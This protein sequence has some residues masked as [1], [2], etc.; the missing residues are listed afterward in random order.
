MASF[1]HGVAASSALDT[2]GERIIIEGMDISSLE[3][4]GVFNYEHKNDQPSQVVGK[5]LKAKKIFSEKDCDNADESYFWEKTQ[6]PFVYVMGELFDD[7][8]E[9]AKE[10]AG[11]FKYDKDNDHK[12]NVCNFS[13][14]GAKLPGS[15]EGMSILRSIARKV[16][17]TVHP[18]NHQAIAEL[19]VVKPEKEPDTLDSIFKTEPIEIELFKSESRITL[20]QVLAKKENPE[21]HAKALGIASMKKDDQK[22]SMAQKSDLKSIM[23]N[24]I[25]HKLSLKEFNP[26]GKKIGTTKGGHEI[27]S[28]KRVHEYSHFHPDDHLEAASLHYGAAQ[29]NPKDAQHHM[30]KVRLHMQAHKTASRREEKLNPHKNEKITKALD[31]GSAMAAPSALSGGAALGMQSMGSMF[32]FGMKRKKKEN[33]WLARAEEEYQTW[34][35]KEEFFNFMQKR[36]PNM[37]KNEID[38]I[39]RT[40]AL[41]KGIENSKK[42]LSKFGMEE[43]RPGSSF[44]AKNEDS[45]SKEDLRKFFAKAINEQAKELKI[46]DINDLC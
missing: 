42:W 26:D 4:D 18:C 25:K 23:P 7:Y 28:H 15:R 12:R 44:I 45:K 43:N 22:P 41:K 2:S 13:I 8:S 31:A 6:C 39:G 10:V 34:E 19:K 21:I 17:I 29:A 35:K 30:D 5:I 37:K 20:A 1:I 9:S 11:K 16:T 3:V 46:K 24:Q 14:E 40:V 36:M 33:P 27:Y 38:A 32:S